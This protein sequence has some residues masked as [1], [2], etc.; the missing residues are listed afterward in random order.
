MES[1]KLEQMKADFRGVIK[2]DRF[3][4]G[5]RTRRRLV[6]H[7]GTSTA[8]AFLRMLWKKDIWIFAAPATALKIRSTE[9]ILPVNGIAVYGVRSLNVLQA[10]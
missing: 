8:R 4:K 1:K 9:V 3:I 10:R 2:K 6:M 7:F 5:E